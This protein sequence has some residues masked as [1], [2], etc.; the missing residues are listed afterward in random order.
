MWCPSTQHALVAQDGDLGLYT[1]VG[2]HYRAICG[3]IASTATRATKTTGSGSTSVKG[4]SAPGSTNDLRAE[5]GLGARTRIDSLEI[6][7]PDGAI[8]R[9][10]DL[11]QFHRFAENMIRIAMIKI[12]L[13]IRVK[14][15]LNRF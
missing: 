13:A 5:I 10:T 14:L 3:S 6:R 7:W 12:T 9:H 11:D 15:Q 1:A 8:E 2:G 4:P